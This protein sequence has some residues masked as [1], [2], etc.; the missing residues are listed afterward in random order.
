MCPSHGMWRV[1]ARRRSASG[2]LGPAFEEHV[3]PDGPGGVQSFVQAV[4]PQGRNGRGSLDETTEHGRFGPL[5][6]AHTTSSVIISAPGVATEIHQPG[7]HWIS[8]FPLPPDIPRIHDTEFREKPGQFLLAERIYMPPRGTDRPAPM[9][10][11]SADSNI[12]PVRN[13]NHNVARCH[14][15]QFRARPVK[16]RNMLQHLGAQYRL[17]RTCPERQPGKIA[18]KAIAVP[19]MERLQIQSNHLAKSIREELGVV[20]LTRAGIQEAGRAPHKRLNAALSLLLLR[21]P[22]VDLKG[23]GLHDGNRAF[24]VLFY[25]ELV[26]NCTTDRRKVRGELHISTLTPRSAAVF[27]NRRD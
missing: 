22:A 23:D 12:L 3:N 13:S 19:E 24:G 1:Q 26:R 4:D 2:M 20:S 15:G 11:H 6:T 16:V 25:D 8:S 18:R 7:S 10:G 5:V 14:S 21:G 9:T 17:D 27:C